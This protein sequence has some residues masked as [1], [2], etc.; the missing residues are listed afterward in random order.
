MRIFLPIQVVLLAWWAAFYPGLFSRD[1]VLYLSH[2][3]IGPWISDHSVLYD[4]LLWLS[5]RGTGDISALTLLQTTAMAAAITYLASSLVALGAPRRWT[6]GLALALPFLPTLGAFSVSFWKDVPFTICAMLIAAVCARVAVD[7]ELRPGRLAALGALFLALGLFRANGFLVVAIA[8]A[9]LVLVVRTMRVR[10][11]LLGMAAAAIP[12]VL[13]NLLFPLVGIA[14][15]TKTYVYHTAFGDI[16]VAFHERPDLFDN[17]DRALLAAV[18][19]L[20]RWDRGGTCATINPLIW[21]GDL[22]GRRRTRTPANCSTCGNGC[23]SASPR[24]WSTP[25]C[26]GARS[27]GRS[28][29]TTRRSAATPTASPAGRTP[30]PTWVWNRCPTTRSGNCS[31][32]ARWTR[33]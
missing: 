20:K 29:P 33:G 25:G 10:L 22:L 9:V 26:A 14:A 24:S 21:R 16:A 13:S 1:S 28:G 7:R 11:A 18:A 32:C 27:R 15:P 31:R 30:T 6:Y 8:V 12:L 17:H 2:T 4:A 3:T 23:W 19:P 5:V